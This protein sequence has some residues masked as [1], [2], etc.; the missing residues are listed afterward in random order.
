LAHL[1][2]RHSFNDAESAA[3]WDRF[4]DAMMKVY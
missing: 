1:G 3:M 4:D 2:P